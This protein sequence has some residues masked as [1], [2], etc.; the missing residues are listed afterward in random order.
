MKKKNIPIVLLHHNEVDYLIKCINS[1]YDNT[2]HPFKLYIVDNNSIKNKK[3][4][5][6][7]KIIK[8]KKIDLFINKKDNWLY[9]FN[10]AIKKINYSWDKIVLSDADILFPKKKGNICWL[11]HL[12]RQLDK[13]CSIGKLGLALD[14]KYLKNKKWFKPL[15]KRELM[16][17]KGEN[18]GENIVAPV[19]TTAAIYRKDLFIHKFYMRVGHV[20]LIRPNYYCCRTNSKWSCKHLGWAKFQETFLKKSYLSK[21]YVRKKAWFFVKFNRSIELSLLFIL[22]PFERFF[23]KFF[24]NITFIYYSL[25]FGFYWLKFVCANFPRK[26]NKI[27]HKANK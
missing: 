26:F 19:D 5:K 11:T 16:Y 9:G 25:I 10:I 1:I 12:S 23:I 2:L 18:I 15:L 13:N 27:Q 6:L 4:D 17:I 14:I 8:N 24:L 21:K 20:S 22:N 7:L 3:F